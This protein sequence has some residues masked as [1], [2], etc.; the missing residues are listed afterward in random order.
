[1]NSL[2]AA[3][4]K[5]IKYEN[6]INQSVSEQ[7]SLKK[8]F[9]D[10]KNQNSHFGKYNTAGAELIHR[11][12]EAILKHEKKIEDYKKKKDE[13]ELIISDHLKLLGDKQ[14]NHQHQ[15]EDLETITYGFYLQNGKVAHN[16]QK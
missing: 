11:A 5:Y 4:A 16:H 14:I 1:M 6:L 12:H 7:E 13:A 2:D 9:D 15:R 3:M 8:R 10:V